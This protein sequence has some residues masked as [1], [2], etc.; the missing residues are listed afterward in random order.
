MNISKNF[1]YEILNNQTVKLTKYIG[2]ENVV[3]IPSMIDDKKV[4]QLGELFEWGNKIIKVIIEDGIEC[5]P[6]ETFFNAEDLLS[7][8]LPQSLKEIEDEAFGNSL[9]LYEIYNLSKLNIKKGLDNYGYI[10]SSA[11]DIYKSLDQV[12]KIVI[13]DKK[14][15]IYNGQK[16][17]L[18]GYLGNKKNIKI[19]DNIDII[20]NFAFATLDIHSVILNSKLKKIEKWAFAWCEKLEY[21]LFPQGL[22]TIESL[23]FK[24]CIS[25]E[26]IKLPSSIK[27]ISDAF[28]QCKN[29]KFFDLSSTRIKELESSLFGLESLEYFYIPKSIKNISNGEFS[30]CKQLKHIEVD[31]NNENFISID[32][33]IYSKDKKELVQYAIGKT[34]KYFTVPKFVERINRDAFIG[35]TY[36][37]QIKFEDCNNWFI[38]NEEDDYINGEIKTRIDA[39]NSFTNAKIL[40]DEYGI[41]FLYKIN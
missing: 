11:K 23:A 17:I 29:I 40:K 2:K 38:T 4:S 33:N 26:Y 41:N 36:L 12:S 24:E 31:K 6:T 16:Q 15:I 39:S 27:S 8:T 9:K 7:I 1:E 3:Y 30:T 14:F 32:G 37:N 10:A 13:N 20:S 19:P 22:I 5:I 18:L 21:I 25:L 34:N 35:A 28:H